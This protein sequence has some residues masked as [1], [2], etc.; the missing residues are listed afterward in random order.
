MFNLSNKTLRMIS[1]IFVAIFIISL[2]VIVVGIVLYFTLRKKEKFTTAL[3][4]NN[5]DIKN[6][7][8]DPLHNYIDSWIKSVKALYST[9]S[10]N[11]NYVESRALKNFNMYTYLDKNPIVTGINKY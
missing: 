5:V 2:I 8:S 7:K 6:D 10:V 9:N 4:T 3:N 1:I 11:E